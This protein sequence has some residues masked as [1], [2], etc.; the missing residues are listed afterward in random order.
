MTGPLGEGVRVGEVVG[1]HTLRDSVSSTYMYRT[2]LV[3]QF[4]DRAGH[5]SYHYLI[6]KSNS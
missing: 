1:R 3:G 5:T 4:I 2:A 6:Q